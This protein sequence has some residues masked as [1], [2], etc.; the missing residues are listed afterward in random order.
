MKNKWVGM[1]KFVLGRMENKMAIRLVRLTIGMKKQALEYR[2]EHFEHNERII[3]G[4]ELL[5]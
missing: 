3:N 5:N 2:Q 4:S 1:W